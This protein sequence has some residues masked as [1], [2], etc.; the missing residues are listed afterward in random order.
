MKSTNYGLA[1][2]TLDATK[3]L[4]AAIPILLNPDECYRC[5]FYSAVSPAPARSVL[6]RLKE[7]IVPKGPNVVETKA[8][9]H[10]GQAQNERLA[11]RAPLAERFKAVRFARL[12][13]RQRLGRR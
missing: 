3:H 10:A 13:I 5:Q 12:V 1:G 2:G 7:S 11:A 6:K 8:G 9:R 4:E